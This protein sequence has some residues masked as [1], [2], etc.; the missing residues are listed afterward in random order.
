MPYTDLWVADSIKI[1]KNLVQFEM[2]PENGGIGMLR[3]CRDDGRQHQ[4]ELVRGGRR[5][6]AGDAAP[7]SR[8]LHTA[9]RMHVNNSLHLT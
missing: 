6:G 9:S 5:E 7:L 3:R 8:A 4:T 2:A 1:S